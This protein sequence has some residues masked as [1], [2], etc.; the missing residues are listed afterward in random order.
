[1][2]S[3]RGLARSFKTRA[4]V[5]DAVRGVSF[6]VDAGEIVGFL[7]P[8]GAGKTT[9]VRMLTTLIAPSSGTAQV[10]GFDIVA[11]RD[12]VRA[13]IGMVSQTGGAGLNHRAGDELR[14]QARLHGMS[15]PTAAA[16]AQELAEEFRLTDLLERQVSSLSGGE[17]RRLDIATGLVHRPRV[18]FLDEP[19]AGLDPQARAHLWEYVRRLRDQHGMTLLLTTHYLDEA[20]LLCDRVLV[21][22]GG[23][24]IAADTPAALKSSLGGDL[25]VLAT[26]RPGDAARVASCHFPGTEP[27]TRPGVVQFHLRDAQSHL[28]ELLR[29]LDASGVPLDSVAVTRPSLD[30]VFLSLTGRALS[31]PRAEDGP[32]P[33]GPAPESVLADAP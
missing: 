26:S 33:S 29:V 23:K 31:A 25:V 24:V 14:T 3:A 8:N 21:I 16:R 13:H 2:I 30:D 10:A 9:T 11:N 15:R 19:T 17:R 4:A 27:D 12:Q 22:D 7:G 18:L 1:M 6:D 20:D 5:V 32:H 28:P